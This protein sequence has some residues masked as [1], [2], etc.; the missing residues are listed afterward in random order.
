LFYEH[1]N[2]SYRFSRDHDSNR[3]RWKIDVKNVLNH[4]L[5]TICSKEFKHISAI[6]D[7]N[8]VTV[9]CV[10]VDRCIKMYYS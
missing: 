6:N 10:I 3:E 5:Y 2:E 7:D 1:V 9:A 4:L 8:T